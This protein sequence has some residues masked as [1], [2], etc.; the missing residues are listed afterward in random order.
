[1]A[2]RRTLG[3]G[4]LGAGFIGNFHVDS[5][6][7]VRD[8]DIVAVCSRRLERAADLAAKAEALGVGSGVT[9]YDE[10]VE[11][12]GRTNAPG[13]WAESRP[14]MRSDRCFGAVAWIRCFRFRSTSQIMQMADLS[15]QVRG[16]GIC[17][18][19]S[20]TNP[21]LLPRSLPRV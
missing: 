17:G 16:N 14:R 15:Q 11:M 4:I 7:G 21:R 19:R 10:I 2:E 3:V 5:F 18:Y 6:R 20:H 13:C 9:A 8:G 12:L 1:M